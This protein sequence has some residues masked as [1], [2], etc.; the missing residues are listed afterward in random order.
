MIFL[1]HDPAACVSRVC[2]FLLYSTFQHCPGS[3][4]N[5]LGK[6][7]KVE[8]AQEADYP[9]HGHGKDPEDKDVPD[10]VNGMNRLLS[11]IRVSSQTVDNGV[12]GRTHDEKMGK[13]E[14][15]LTGANVSEA[16]L[17]TTKNL[18]VE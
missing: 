5:P 17:R 18:S 16:S 7:H 2:Y 11:G 14:A 3:F 13:G 4:E 8:D 6:S 9:D 12:V 1:V 10:N 15:C